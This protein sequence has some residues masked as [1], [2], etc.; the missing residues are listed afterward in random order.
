MSPGLN[1]YCFHGVPL[2]LVM[3]RLFVPNFPDYVC[4][5][6]LWVSFGQVMDVMNE[7]QPSLRFKLRC[8]LKRRHAMSLSLLSTRP[9]TILIVSSNATHFYRKGNSFEGYT[10]SD[11]AFLYGDVEEEENGDDDEEFSV[12][13]SQT[14]MFRRRKDS[15][16]K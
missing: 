14:E 1:V 12:A 9:Q 11:E 3:D 13:V 10:L 7:K 8:L 16:S 2:L 15:I 6:M 5:T 4:K